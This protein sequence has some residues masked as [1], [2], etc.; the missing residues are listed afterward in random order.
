MSV[1]R[2]IALVLALAVATMACAVP[3]LPTLPSADEIATIV[4][5]T[6]MAPE[7]FEPPAAVTPAPELPPTPVTPAPLR[8]AYTDAGNVWLLEEGGAPVQLTMG[9]GAHSVRIS[10]D[11]QR[12]A[13]LWSSTPSDHVELR[14]VNADGSA[15]TTLLSAAAL[16]A[17]YPLP[18]GVIG[19]QLWHFEFIPN[20]HTIAFTTTGIPEFIGLHRSD[21]LLTVDADSG[22]LTTLLPP[23][24][25]GT[26]AIAPDGSRI[27]IASP[28]AIG[29]V[30]AD[31]SSHRPDLITYPTII[32]YSE[33]LFSPPL[34]WAPD[35]SAVGV[36]IPS[37]DPL[38]PSPGGAVWR[39]P[40]AGGPAVMLSTLSGQLYFP[41][42]S[43]GS[44]L[45]PDL[46]RV[47]ILRD[48]ATPNIRQLILANADGTGEMVYV[49]DDVQWA[50][51]A[52]DSL[53]F[54]YGAGSP[55][56]LV[57]GQV[58]GAPAPIGSGTSL[59]WISATEF[60]YLTGS[61]GSWSLVRGGIGGASTTLVSP[62]GDFVAF[63]VN[64]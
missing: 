55:T 58:G 5:A 62:A 34:V 3:G 24:S 7:P 48:T 11:G 60:L 15:A 40:A 33:F 19:W 1:R 56:S 42:M 37:D 18:G 13:Y 31:G 36:V 41:Q 53:H 51:W 10:S 9:G 61:Y 16:D 35:S 32:T 21:D 23:G 17:L 57:L 54:V 59:R 30:D 44:L 4:A 47:V 43:G 63:D 6:L 38:A 46:A 45:S 2:V 27:A 12:I 14:A 20:T 39:I 26:F 52:P 25:G 64:R 22:A 28:N 8:I 49:T 50:G 29:L